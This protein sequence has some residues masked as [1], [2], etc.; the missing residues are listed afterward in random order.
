M[1]TKAHSSLS[2]TE[3]HSPKYYTLSAVIADV[4][5]AETVYV[6]IPYAG[7]VAK[8]QSVLEGALTSADATITVKDSAGNSMGSL[9]IAH[10]SSAAGDVDTLSPPS[11][12]DVTAGDFITIETD[13]GSTGTKK[14]WLTVVVETS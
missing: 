3:L 5:T 14:L 1:A 4:S 12:E 8:V 6:P 2:T 9:T 10:T 7:T 13:G 11:N